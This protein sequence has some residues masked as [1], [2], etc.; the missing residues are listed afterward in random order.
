MKTITILSNLI[1]LKS[2]GRNII[3]MSLQISIEVRSY[4]LNEGQFHT[5]FLYQKQT[6]YRVL[7]N[8]IY[9]LK[10]FTFFELEHY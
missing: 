3:L 2:L 9:F 6:Y 10:N 5:I 4:I 8:F 1:A 7:K